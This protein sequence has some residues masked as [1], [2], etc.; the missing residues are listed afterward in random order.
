[1]F[2]TTNDNKKVYLHP[3]A[4]HSH[5]PELNE[6]V[7][8]K[9]NIGDNTFIKE[10]VDLGRVIG[11]DHLVE[12][13]EEDKIVLL[14]RGRG[15]P[16]R[17]VI[18]RDPENTTKAT[19]IIAKCGPED[20]EEWDD[21]YVLI[22]LFEGEPGEPEPYGRNE[23]NQNAIEFWKTHALVPTEEEKIRLSL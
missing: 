5:R 11:K 14:D 17:M 4:S 2:F 6:E 7:L 15:Y 16:S 22:T 19:V 10:V 18:G 20:G 8:S 3:Q 9:I 13:T 12:T 21:K 23:N 1:M